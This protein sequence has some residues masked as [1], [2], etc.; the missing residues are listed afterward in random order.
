MAARQARTERVQMRIDPAAKSLL[1]RAAALS[2]TTVSAFIVS[3]ALKAASHLI[4][5]R[6]RFV[7]SDQDWNLFFDA[8]ADPP[9]PNAALRKAF[10]AH[11]PRCCVATGH[12]SNVRTHSLN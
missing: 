11:D 10:V 6:E 4:R 3:H 12:G 5:E 7:V 8:L 1:E 2:N 9:E